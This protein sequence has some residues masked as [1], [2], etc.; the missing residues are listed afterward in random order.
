MDAETVANVATSAEFAAPPR[1]GKGMGRI[2]PSAETLQQV[3]VASRRRCAICFGLSRDL[4][5]KQGQVAHIDRDASNSEADNLLFMCLMHHD[6]YDTRRSQSKGFTE[7]EI[8]YYQTELGKAL[9]SLLIQPIHT[10]TATVRMPGD[11]S[12]RYARRAAVESA[13]LE[14]TLLPGGRHIRVIG[15]ALW[16][17]H[18]RHGPNIGELDFESVLEGIRT[19]YVDSTI[20]ERP[21]RLELEFHELGLRATESEWLGYFGMN[22]SFSGDYRRCD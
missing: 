7:S 1:G 17:T 15:L 18:R 5:L 21:Y 11:P 3:L 16:G 19:S 6:E 10:I 20:R 13:E 9:Q 22:V 2:P 4:G 12:G 14:I 8:R